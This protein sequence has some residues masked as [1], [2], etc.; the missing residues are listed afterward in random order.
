M[1]A[2]GRGYEVDDRGNPI[3]PGYR[4]P[5]DNRGVNKQVDIVI[6]KPKMDGSGQGQ[7]RGM[8]QMIEAMGGT[9]MPPMNQGGLGNMDVLMDMLRGR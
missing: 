1:K 8:E 9:V 4:V 2:C 5:I 7:R 6:A 3:E